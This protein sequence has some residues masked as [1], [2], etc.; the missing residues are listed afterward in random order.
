MK[1]TCSYGTTVP[2]L[3]VQLF[4]ES[5]A[6]VQDE[7]V[8]IVVRYAPLLL[9]RSRVSVKDNRRLGA[10]GTHGKAVHRLARP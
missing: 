1:D 2:V 8:H 7:V 9:A 4:D 5:F 6:P 3:A 10:S